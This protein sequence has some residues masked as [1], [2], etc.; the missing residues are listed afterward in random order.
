MMISICIDLIELNNRLSKIKN[1]LSL[2]EN[3][4]YRNKKILSEDDKKNLNILH[5][6]INDIEDILI[7]ILE[8]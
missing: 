1:D 2:I 6:N 3:F 5:R 4:T 7:N 8:K